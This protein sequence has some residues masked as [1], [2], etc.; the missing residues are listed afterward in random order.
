V[1]GAVLPAGLFDRYLAIL[2]ALAVLT[3]VQGTFL[4]WDYGVLDGSPIHWL[5]GWWRGAIDTTLWLLVLLGT[6]LGY[7]RFGRPVAL[8]AA[9]SFLI[10][11][12]SLLPMIF[13]GDAVATQ[14]GKG[15]LDEGAYAA[16]SQF[17]RNGNVLHIVMDG[18]QSDI[19]SEIVEDPEYGWIADSLTGFTFF[20]EHAGTFPY[21]QMTVPLI[22][23][24]R[25]YRNEMPIDDFTTA[26]MQ[27]DTILNVCSIIFT[28]EAVNPQ[29]T[30]CRLT[31][32]A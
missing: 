27:G 7:R 10:Q 2:A 6:Y 5:E 30:L 28:R 19:F 21:T 24:G 4:V 15:S 29:F 23:S 22:V 18:F 20:D 31:V 16:M 17:S 3:W 25:T 12:V 11:L 13:S 26:A 9:A 32:T 8:A 14:S 1:I